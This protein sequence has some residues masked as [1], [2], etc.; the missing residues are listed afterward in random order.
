M[1]TIIEARQLR[2]AHGSRPVFDDISFNIEQ[3]DIVALLGANGAGKT[4][5]LNLIAGLLL[6]GSGE[7]LINGRELRA[8][9][10]REL[11]RFIALVPQHLEI[12]FSFRVEEIVAQGRVPYLG[13]FGMLSTHDYDVIEQAMAAVDITQLRDRVFSELSGGERQRVKLAI[14]LAQEP[15]VMLLDEPMQ[16]LDIGR[17]I[18]LAGL[19]KKM[20]QS[21]ITIMAAAHDLSAIRENFSRSVLLYARKCISGQT[22]EVMQPDLLE[23]AFSV[24]AAALRFYC[25]KEMTSSA[26]PESQR[27]CR[28]APERKRR[29]G[30]RGFLPRP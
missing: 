10:R 16:H 8:W 17:Q 12:P 6:P 20:N 28:R 11:S 4:T 14:G 19:L 22:D 13:H 30:R 27:E 21:G 18:E 9:R 25:E 23:R 1:A 29:F 26:L 7:I 5:L 2:F 3:G 24:D 15:R